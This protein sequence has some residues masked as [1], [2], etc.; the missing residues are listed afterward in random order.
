MLQ[1]ASKAWGLSIAATVSRLSSMGVDFGRPITPEVIE[2]YLN[3]Y[4]RKLDRL[5]D[6]WK[7]ARTNF[8]QG[9]V[10]VGQLLQ[11]LNL[12]SD[13]VGN[14]LSNG[15]GMIVGAVAAHTAE[16]AFSPGSMRGTNNP[17]AER[18]FKGVWKDVLAMPFY[19]QPGRIRGFLYI[20]RQG[21]IPED[22][23]F[24]S[25]ALHSDNRNKHY[26]AGLAYHP[27]VLN[28]D[29][30]YG[31]AV[32]AVEDP[33]L[34]LRLQQRHFGFS[35]RALPIAVWRD[36]GK[37]STRS[38][39]IFHSRRIVFWTEKPTAALV[40]QLRQTD[41]Y[42]TI[43][44]DQ[45]YWTDQSTRNSARRVLRAAL[46]WHEALTLWLRQAP[47]ADVEEL[48][49]A[50]KIRGETPTKIL[51][52]CPPELQARIADILR[53]DLTQKS[54]LCGKVSVMEQDDGWYGVDVRRNTSELI[55]DA[56]LRIERVLYQPRRQHTYYHGF[57]RYKG[58][59]VP[60]CARR[61]VIEKGTFKWMQDFLM[62]RNKGYL[63]YDPSWSTK[64]VKVA[65]ELYAPE[66]L[67]GFDTVGWDS[68]RNEFI[69]PT[70]S[71][72]TNGTVGGSHTQ[73]FETDSPARRLGL[74]QALSPAESESL[75]SDLSSVRVV[76]GGVGCLIANILAP[77]FDEQTS[78]LAL[79]GSGA[80]QAGRV[81]ACAFDCRRRSLENGRK[82]NEQVLADERE[83]NWPTYMEVPLT[84]MPSTVARWLEA[85]GRVRNAMAPT[86]W[87]HAVPAQ[88]LGGWR[89]LKEDASNAIPGDLAPLL[90]KAIPSYLSY[91]L[92]NGMQIDMGEGWL[93]G[94]FHSIAA[95]VDYSGGDPA[96][97]LS[98]LE[99]VVNDDYH[100]IADS[101]GDLLCRLYV[102]GKL[103]YSQPGFEGEDKPTL[104][105][106][107][108]GGLSV[109]KALL[110]LL[111]VKGR[112]EI[113]PIRVTEVL[114]GAE[115]LLG[116]TESAWVIPQTWWSSKLHA[117][118]AVRARLLRVK[119]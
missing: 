34:M 54:V 106:T 49:Q 113:E 72:S 80:E 101:F 19:D 21:R 37:Y 60:F 26:E 12:R 58:E 89:L 103:A 59:E 107:D 82:Q 77:A 87:L 109:P 28:Q 78:G 110:G 93:R 47:D 8:I 81:L 23:A 27:D 48:F 11:A 35:T 44:A 102:D 9:K 38:W 5:T 24:K 96:V 41:G 36:D 117:W 115:L 4:V 104:V 100:G 56:C 61:E 83:H 94:V 13:L 43:G 99:L 20:G 86:D 74:P 62:A 45:E 2:E 76:W 98:G 73:F 63:R 31:N 22:T 6:H 10:S 1:L 32:I 52:R 67:S 65:T 7:T 50:M 16:A 29:E 51:E 39:Q 53:Q 14:R 91:L 114:A 69:F 116:E 17:S 15:P 92:A 88:F 111:P 90:S 30:E 68:R 118:R 112:I 66:F 64:A 108:G 40:A 57:I 95:W 25:V 46:P 71:I 70:F 79:V 75:T 33:L 97:V 85:G 18:L 3:Q 105:P 55:A 119:T 84:T 42:L